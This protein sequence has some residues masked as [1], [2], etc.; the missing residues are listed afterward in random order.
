[1]KLISL[2]WGRRT[3]GTMDPSFGVSPTAVKKYLFIKGKLQNRSQATLRAVICTMNCWNGNTLV[4]YEVYVN[5]GPAL[6]GQVF[7]FDI[8]TADD[9]TVNNVTID[10]ADASGKEIVVTKE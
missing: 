9:P 3:E 2:E 6:P 10:F 4:K 5:R 7:A 8:Q 1:M